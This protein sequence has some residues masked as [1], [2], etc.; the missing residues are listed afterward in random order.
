MSYDLYF[1]STNISLEDFTA[2]FRKDS[3]YK[4]EKNQ[5]F[6]TNETTGVYFSFDHNS[7]KPE[8]KDD[9]DYSVAFNI[10]YYRPH[11]FALEAEPEV[12]RFIQH[13]NCAI[14][15]VQNSGMG[16]GPY[17]REGFLRGWNAGNE[18]GYQAILS[19][20][21]AHGTI[22]T[23]PTEELEKVWRWNISAD[24]RSASFKEDIF[25]PRIMFMSFDGDFGTVCIWPDG[26]STLIPHVDFLYVPRKELAPKKWFKAPEE[27]FCVVPRHSFPEFFDY[28]AT[29]EFELRSSKLP[30]PTTPQ[31]V[32]HYVKKLKPFAGKVTRIHS[33]SVLNA[34]LVA[35]FKRHE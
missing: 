14:R 30:A 1:T 26:I 35:K 2:Y 21:D 31:V 15:D 10:N 16:D 24:E 4:V 9:I 27:D 5:A 12:A 25:V 8:D 7:N 33:D 19:R 6:Y 22:Y 18:F 28:Y 17:T 3:R 34:E 32:Q 20:D 23:K 13:F 29:D 11:F